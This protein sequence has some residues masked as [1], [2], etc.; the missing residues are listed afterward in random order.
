MKTL[1]MRRRFDN[2]LFR[3]LF[4]EALN[5][6]PGFRASLSNDYTT[7][8][9]REAT[10]LDDVGEFRDHYWSSEA[11]SKT[12]FDIG[13]DRENAA[14]EKFFVA[15]GHC[16]E[17]NASLVGWDTR[18]SV[19]FRLM[20]RARRIVSQVLGEFSLNEM[21]D[22]CSFGPGATT[23]LPRHKARQ[24]EKWQLA[25]HITRDALPY[26]D[27]FARFNSGW[28]SKDVSELEIVIGNKVTT[29]PKSAK[30]DRVIAIEPD[31]NMFFQRAV[32]NMIRRR[33]QRIGLLTPDA[34]EVNR[35]YAREGSITGGYSTIDLSSAS[36]SISL[37]L[38]EA[39]L[40]HSWMQ[41]LIR[42]R[43]PVGTIAG[44]TVI[45][46]KIS[47]MG[48]GF[49]FELETL[50]FYALARACCN[51]GKVLVYGDD[52]IIPVR[53]HESVVSALVNSGFTVNVKKT[54]S[55]GP[56][57]ESCGGHYHTGKEVTPPYFKEIEIR[58]LPGVIRTANRLRHYASQRYVYFLDARF[59]DAWEY[60]ASFVPKSFRGPRDLGDSC[61]HTSFDEAVP[62]WDRNLQNWKVKTVLPRTENRAANHWGGVY[63]SLWGK[64]SEA[65]VGSFN[66]PDNVRVAMTHTSG[67]WES[68]DQWV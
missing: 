3:S 31:W 25:S 54:F 27:A 10:I 4:F 21:A 39:L 46:E 1:Q 35:K 63:S 56:F 6:G 22:E 18:P 38:C 52:I 14:Y 42:L 53:Y 15:E 23:S 30:V 43:S 58:T 7:L 49:T 60:C 32:G 37:A 16:R 65:S 2:S 26:Y 40:P 34:Q 57:R 24:Q 9:S 59:S 61:L 11:Y 33:L 8:V 28:R 67:R 55:S 51:E 68:P 13:V 5:D 50:L 47:S 45:Y 17:A 29:V 48:N 64:V 66:Q 19:D 36:D 41:Q 62:V 12:P 44:K 20:A